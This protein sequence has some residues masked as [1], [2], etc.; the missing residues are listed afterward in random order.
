MGLVRAPEERFE[1]LPGYSY[2]VNYVDVG[3]PEMAYVDEAGGG[4]ETFLCLHGEPTWSY[5]YR[6]MIPTLSERGRVIA[7]DLIGFGRSDKWDDQSEYTYSAM[8]DTVERFV[9]ELDLQNVT[10]VCQDWG[11]LLGLP[12]AANN[13]GRFARLV[14]MNTGLPDGTQTMPDVWHQ[15][16]DMTKNAPEL[17]VGQLINA[18]CL[19]DL[20]D[21]VQ[22]AYAAPFPDDSHTAGARILPSRVPIEPEMEGA[23]TI[24]AARDTFADWDKPV[25]VLFSDSDPITR[26]SRDDLRELFPTA[27]DQPDI[28][29]EGGAHFLQE[30]VGETVA[31]RIVEFVDRT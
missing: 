12:V 13:P 15:F 26:G 16:K 10:L 23:D 28:W 27:T 7:P 31:T 20:D 30:D 1:G 17:D 19:N 8:Y 18:G 14:P 5:L 29:V 11:G 4:D 3:G 22:A 24:A 9:T 2:D 25:F 6:K 21:D